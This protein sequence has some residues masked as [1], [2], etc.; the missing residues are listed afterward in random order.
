M[1]DYRLLDSYEAYC[2]AFKESKKEARELQIL[3]SWFST[4][5]KNCA[6]IAPG[7]SYIGLD[8]LTPVDQIDASWDALTY[9]TDSAREAFSR[10]ASNMRETVLREN[11]LMPV[12]KVKE[13]NSAGMIWLCRQPGR[14]KKE[15]IS[16]TRALLGVNRRMSLDTGENRL[17]KAFARMLLDTIR[18]KHHALPPSGHHPAE[19]AFI[20]HL[21][22]F[23]QNPENEEIRKWENLP[24]NNTLLSDKNYKVIWSA[25]MA[26]QNLDSIIK[27]DSLH[28]SERLMKIFYIELLAR[29]R[30]YIY[31]P[32]IPIDVS[33]DNFIFDV[34]L[35]EICGYTA[36]H[37]L[38]QIT[39]KPDAVTIQCSQ[40]YLCF[41]RTFLGEISSYGD[42]LAKVETAVE[43]ITSF[44]GTTILKKEEPNKWPAEG[45][46]YV[47]IFS[48]VPKILDT[49]GDFLETQHRVLFQEQM[50]DTAESHKPY[51]LSCDRSHILELQD[52]IKTYSVKSCVE[53]ENADILGYLM[54]KLHQRLKGD[55]IKMLVNDGYN[56]FQLRVLHKSGRSFFRNVALFPESIAAAFWYQDTSAFQDHFSSGDIVVV[57]NLS[58]DAYT[59]TPIQ[60]FSREFG[61]LWERYPTKIVPSDLLD[62][63]HK[64]LTALGYPERQI[65]ELMQFSG[66]HSLKTICQKLYFQFP[67]QGITDLSKQFNQLD[68]ELHIEVSDAVHTISEQLRQCRSGGN[69]T[70]THV[71]LKSRILSCS[72]VDFCT[73][74]SAEDILSGCKLH[75]E[76]SRQ[77][78][79]IL[80]HDHLPNLSIKQ[81][82]GEFKLINNTTAIPVFGEKQTIRIHQ[83]IILKKDRPEHHFKLVQNENGS[84]MQFEAVVRNAAFPLSK[85]TECRLLMTYQYGA[86]DPYTLTFVPVQPATAE[87]RAAKVK[88]Q[89]R[90]CYDTTFLRAPEFPSPMSWRETRA[91]PKRKGEGTF[92]L[93]DWISNALEKYHESMNRERYVV[94]FSDTSIHIL[95][96]DAKEM[97]FSMPY[98]G[99]IREVILHRNNY[100]YKDEYR[101]NPKILS[102]SLKEEKEDDYI[103]VNLFN[104]CNARWTINEYGYYCYLNNFR[105][106]ETGEFISVKLQDT[107]FRNPCEFNPYIWNVKF[108][109]YYN[110]KSNRYFGKNITTSLVPQLFAERIRKGHMADDECFLKDKI[111]FPLHTIYVSG[112]TVRDEEC[113]AELHDVVQKY[114]PEMPS[115]YNRIGHGHGNNNPKYMLLYIM[116]LMHNELGHDFYQIAF[117][118]VENYQTNPNNKLPDFIGYALDA[119]VTDD[120]KELLNKILL[121]RSEK[122]LCI[123]SKAAWKHKDFI[124]N[125]PQLVL[126]K[127]F[128]TAIDKLCDYYLDGCGAKI[129]TPDLGAYLEFIL[130]VFRLRELHDEEL[131]NTLS[132]NNPRMQR[133]YSCLEEIAI[134]APKLNTI[135]KIDVKKS[136][137]YANV[138]E[139][140]YAVACYITGEMGDGDIIITGLDDN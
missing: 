2:S 79:E 86:E 139:I 20:P 88:W 124:F 115:W 69:D 8:Q 28:C 73:Y 134:K 9:I 120:Q 76:L 91:I 30:C 82:F 55:S 74:L 40:L 6:R 65:A 112:R 111:L 84:V 41:D 21:T 14:T 34:K 12:Y 101:D 94:N 131:N 17:V 137:D 23:L 110:K 49:N 33:Y 72:G 140:V 42:I 93:C 13:I 105:H 31:L 109:L 47:D 51:F 81:L 89:R 97:V 4:Q 61:I 25:W 58:G 104:Y 56:D 132:L 96:E 119:C 57:V 100:I 127:M 122:A 7:R 128:Y 38:V 54:R 67:E 60:G 83:T 107:N 85:D 39:A 44:T 108:L 37:C 46:M 99:K 103:T 16:N 138:P 62:T 3:R 126:E 10:I 102:F 70:R 26:L 32:Q 90:D 116:S 66:L 50:Y 68:E 27:D 113:P 52:G 24:P 36:N 98:G 59:V 75:D 71:L 22:S 43:Q 35:Q 1:D 5:L 78:N 117:D 123:L 133:L 29:L 95:K 15:K 130:A 118:A 106:P 45:S 19:L 87:F 114:A 80:W 18:M 136:S 135:L 64:K 129:K 48:V 77:L 53:S 63:V 92:D 121:L 11:I 125:L